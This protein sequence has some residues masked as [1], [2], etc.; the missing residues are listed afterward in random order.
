M[1][2]GVQKESYPNVIVSPFIKLCCFFSLILK[3]F[4]FQS[5]TWDSNRTS[6]MRFSLY[7]YENCCV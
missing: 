7:L 4:A 6:K 5:L 2:C 3:S 1:P